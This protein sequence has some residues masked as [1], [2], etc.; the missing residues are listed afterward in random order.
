MKSLFS[1]SFLGNDFIGANT[2]L[3]NSSLRVY[4][5]YYPYPWE[6]LIDWDKPTWRLGRNAGVEVRQSNECDWS[7]RDRDGNYS[8]PKS[9]LDNEISHSGHFDCNDALR[10]EILSFRRIEQV[11]YLRR[12]KLM[13]E[14]SRCSDLWRFKTAW[15]RLLGTGGSA[16]EPAW[17]AR[18]ARADPCALECT[19]HFSTFADGVKSKKETTRVTL[20]ELLHAY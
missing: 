19:Q 13:V 4:R 8:K 14:C 10:W 20:Y 5:M 16:L 2:S 11:S 18:P 9:R 15:L 1:C 6:R 17:P 3:I 12:S 7:G